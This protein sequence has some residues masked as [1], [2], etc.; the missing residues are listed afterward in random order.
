VKVV[1]REVDEQGRIVIP[2]AWRKEEGIDS[3]AKIELIKE[4]NKIFIKPLRYKSLSEVRIKGSSDLNK[5]E[6]AEML[7]AVKRH[8]KSRR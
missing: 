3:N 8:K 2:Y 1:I 7:A 4:G 5:I 6:K